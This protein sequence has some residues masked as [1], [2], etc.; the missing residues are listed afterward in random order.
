MRLFV[1]YAD[2][3]PAAVNIK[4]HKL[5]ILSPSIDDMLNELGRFGGDEIREIQIDEKNPDPSNVLSGLA[6]SINGG[7]VLT[8]PGESLSALIHNLEDQLP[9]LH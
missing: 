6:A 2:N 4:G 3:S 7:V 8:G 1:P 9:W 5:L